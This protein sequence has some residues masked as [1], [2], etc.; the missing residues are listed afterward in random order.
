[1]INLFFLL[2][3]FQ[4]IK[5]KINRKKTIII[6]RYI[7]FLPKNIVFTLKLIIGII[8]SSDYLGI[9]VMKKSIRIFSVL[10]SF[11]FLFISGAC[12]N[13]DDLDNQSNDEDQYQNISLSTELFIADEVPISVDHVGDYTGIKIGYPGSDHFYGI[14]GEYVEDFEVEIDMIF[15]STTRLEY[16]FSPNQWCVAEFI[17]CDL[18]GQKLF[19]I[20]RDWLWSNQLEVYNVGYIIDYRQNPN[21]YYAQGNLYTDIAQ[22][23]NA[24]HLCAP[25]YD[26]ATKP[27]WF[28]AEVVDDQILKIST[29]VDETSS[30]KL[31]QT[32]MYDVSK[33]FKIKI[34]DGRQRMLDYIS[35]TN[36]QTTREFR[37]CVL[38]TSLKTKKYK[39]I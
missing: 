32:F 14:G 24:K 7:V 29:S 19:G 23:L 13:N 1:M 37:T 36:M 38:V 33:G 27:G 16:L 4:K 35:E 20:V 11:V 12:S 6:S 5:F 28:L 21:I 18:N 10:L 22:V 15:N 9:I 31:E 2:I 25:K 39:S 34:R 26:D 3:C 30:K 17:I 8:L